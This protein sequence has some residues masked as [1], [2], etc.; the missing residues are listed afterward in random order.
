MAIKREKNDNITDDK[1]K[2]YDFFF[3]WAFRLVYALIS[4]AI[5]IYLVS[6]LIDEDI[7]SNQWRAYAILQVFVLYSNRKIIS[8]LFR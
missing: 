4:I 5:T 8:Y 6:K 3:M 7:S 1:L 2:V